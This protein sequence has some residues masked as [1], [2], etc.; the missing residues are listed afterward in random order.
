MKKLRVGIIGCGTILPVHLD[1][2]HAYE[3]AD[4][5]V[6]CDIDGP[7]AKRVADKEDCRWTNDYKEVLANDQVDL[8]HIL[9]PHYLH[10]PMA[11]EAL[12]GGK[13]VV[14]EKPVGIDVD[15]LDALIDL[16]RETGLTL[17][18]TL[19]NRFNPT[20]IKMKEIAESGILGDFLAAKGLLTWSRKDTYY[21]DSPWRG[22]LATEGGGLLIN[23][24]I[25]T[26]DLLTY[27]GGPLKEIKASVVNHA[28][29]Y[30]EVED[31]AMVTFIYANGAVGN[32]YGTNNYGDNTPIELGFVFEKGQLQ[33]KNEQL[34]LIQ[35]DRAEVI[36]NDKVKKGEKSYWG[37]SHQRI[38]RDI[39]ESIEKKISPK[40]TLEDAV[41][42]TKL[43]L[44]CYACGN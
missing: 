11:M 3:G 42:T 35:G 23:Q 32:F 43:V 12:R 29:P 13:H 21:T 2:I 30:I 36:A 24:G 22:K 19:Q 33:L 18:V 34:I 8:V 4:L 41:K 31:T 10:T 40:V 5:V 26:L 7:L 15:Q 20:T 39:Y 44:A 14:L 28:H 17:G 25:H 9:T 1:S 6:V 16:A 37:M 27:I 38:I